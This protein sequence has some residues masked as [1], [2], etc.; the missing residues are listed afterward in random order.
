MKRITW[1]VMA[2]ALMLPW[3]VSANDELLKLQN[4]DSVWVIPGKNYASTRYSVLNQI[5]PTLVPKPKQAWSFS[6]G[7]LRGHEGQPLVVSTTLYV[8]SS[9]PTHV[10]ALALPTERARTT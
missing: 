4:D 1:L 6:T 10:H 7:A 9:Y 3:D 8:N 2:L 5:T